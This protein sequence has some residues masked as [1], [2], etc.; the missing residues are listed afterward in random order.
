[1]K[2]KEEEEKEKKEEDKKKKKNKNSNKNTA[3]PRRQNFLKL[4]FESFLPLQPTSG[5]SVTELV[6]SRGL[7]LLL[8]NVIITKW[9]S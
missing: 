7:G 3:F 2:K 4:L 5:I 6:W 1:M 8:L 9:M